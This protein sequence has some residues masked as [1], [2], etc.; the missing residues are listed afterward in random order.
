MPT[1]AWSCGPE[2][3]K[4]AEEPSFDLSCLDGEE[5]QI[6]LRVAVNDLRDQKVIFAQFLNE[7]GH[8]DKSNWN[9][10]VEYSHLHLLFAET[11]VSTL[12]AESDRRIMPPSGSRSRIVAA[13]SRAR[14]LVQ[15]RLQS[16]ETGCPESAAPFLE[17]RDGER[18]ALNRHPRRDDT[19]ALDANWRAA[20]R[21]R[22]H[23]SPGAVVSQTASAFSCP[24]R[25]VLTGITD[26][27]NPVH[28]GSPARLTFPST[29]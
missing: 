24:L 20:L 17:F 8:P 6:A 25:P 29:K 16:S 19:L 14:R 9:R 12:L 23:R 3:S 1:S 11:I 18:V 28:C 27:L 21:S 22:G 15:G 26:G 13:I 5:F 10:T 2:M 7:A 4:Y